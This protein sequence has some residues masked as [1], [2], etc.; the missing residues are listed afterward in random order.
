[1]TMGGQ[2]KGAGAGQLCIERGG[3]GGVQGPR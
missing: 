2:G 3:S 1:V